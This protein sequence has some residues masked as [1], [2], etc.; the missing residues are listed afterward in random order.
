MPFYFRETE[1][2]FS[3]SWQNT[4]YSTAAAEVAT[5][6]VR[7]AMDGWINLLLL[8]LLLSFPLHVALD[9]MKKSRCWYRLDSEQTKNAI[10]LFAL[11]VFLAGSA[12]SYVVCLRKRQSVHWPHPPKE[13]QISDNK[14]SSNVKIIRHVPKKFSTQRPSSFWC[15]SSIIPL[16]TRRK[17]NDVTPNLD[18]CAVVKSKTTD[19]YYSDFDLSLIQNY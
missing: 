16:H 4:G 3:V 12:L 5:V 2:H 13:R 8:L 18:G 15:D 1:T 6:Q 9:L 19:D 11:F 10:T 14:F 7:C 17:M